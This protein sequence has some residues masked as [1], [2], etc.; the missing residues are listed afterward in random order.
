[1]KRTV[2]QARKK[3]IVPEELVIFGQTDVRREIIFQQK[4]GE[5]VPVT[6][7]VILPQIEGAIIIASRST[8]MLR[9]V[10]I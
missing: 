9:F 4:N 6:Q 2:L 5:S 3:R 1:M 7:R 8:E 10:L